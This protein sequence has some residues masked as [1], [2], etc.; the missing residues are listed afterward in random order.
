MGPRWTLH[1]SKSSRRGRRLSHREGEHINKERKRLAK[2]PAV[3]VPNR[4]FL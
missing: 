1:R 3:D 4:A 2:D